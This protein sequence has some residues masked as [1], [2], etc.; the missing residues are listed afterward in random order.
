MKRLVLIALILIPMFG[1]TQSAKK[2]KN[3]K[4][5]SKTITK[6]IA[7]DTV[8]VTYIDTYE[9]YNSDGKTI[10]EIK[11][12]MDGVVRRKRAFKYDAFDNVIEELEYDQKK[13]KTLITTYKYNA[14]GNE[15]EKNT[16]DQDGVMVEK[17]VYTYNKNRLK[18]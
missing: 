8:F 16:T 1:F 3:N 6:T 2:I 18:L 13:G 12:S 9:E 4:I 11:Y 7:V 17:Q 14:D 10:T 5:S 15:I